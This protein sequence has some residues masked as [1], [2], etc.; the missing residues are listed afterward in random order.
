MA[1]AIALVHLLFNVLGTVVFY[2]LPGVRRLPPLLARRLADVA[3]CNKAWLAV[4]ALGVFV[5]I[6]LAGI[7]LFK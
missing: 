7:L 2:G 1:L 6:P 4:Y 3:A 5:L